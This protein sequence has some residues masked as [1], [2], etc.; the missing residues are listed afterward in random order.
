MTF[1]TAAGP[2]RGKLASNVAFRF[3]QDPGRTYKFDL[4]VS[5]GLN[6]RQFGLLALR[7]VLRHFALQT[8]GAM[9]HD[10]FDTPIELPTLDLFPYG[11]W[12]R[13]SYRCPECQIEVWGRPG[14][15]L[16]CNDHNR[17]LEPR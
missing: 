4:L 7:D 14:L 3:S 15:E 8:E 17:R 2:G 10:L 13:I 5:A 11:G 12:Q 6:D 16:V 9:R 1:R